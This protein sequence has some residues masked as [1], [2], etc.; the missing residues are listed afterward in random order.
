MGAVAAVVVDG[1]DGAMVVSAGEGDA[2][3]V[4]VVSGV[5]VTA[6][7]FGWLAFWALAPAAMAIEA[8]SAEA[9]ARVGMRFNI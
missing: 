2:D 4:V 5:V 7:S 9:I 1:V 6:G 8:A 3:G